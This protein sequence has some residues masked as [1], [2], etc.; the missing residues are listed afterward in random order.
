MPSLP[1]RNW[2]LA[3]AVKK[4]IKVDIKIFLYCP[5][6]LDFWIFPFVSNIFSGIVDFQEIIPSF[7]SFKNPWKTL[8]GQ[9]SEFHGNDHCG[10]A[11]VPWWFNLLN[12]FIDSHNIFRAQT[13]SWLIY[14]WRKNTK[15]ASFFLNS[16]LISAHI[17]KFR[18]LTVF[19]KNYS[20]KPAKNWRNPFKKCWNL[21]KS[22]N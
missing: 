15:F 19:A 6:F 14:K 16:C 2:T 7:Q 17:L 3:R 22:E 18:G 10:S 1:S 11:K 9:V 8:A 20:S 21:P 4:H 5:T 12:R 13:F